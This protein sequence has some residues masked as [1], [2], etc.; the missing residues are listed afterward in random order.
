MD[1]SNIRKILIY[2][3]DFW[4]FYNKQSQKVKD[5]I[6]WTIR[7]VSELDR[8]PEK[9]F[10]HI[11]GTELYEIRIISGNNIYRVY[12]FFDRGNLV[13]VLNA[14]QKKSQ[15]TPKNQIERALKL[16][17]EYYEDKKK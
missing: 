12:C 10:K 4:E 14:F 3:D 2:G 5:R 11:I 15:K 17:A 16:R 8:I 6:N 9:Y 7:L 1:K 13:V